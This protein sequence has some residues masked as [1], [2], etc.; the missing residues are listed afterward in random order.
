MLA[1]HLEKLSV[2]NFLVFVR[3]GIIASG[4]GRCMWPLRQRK[5]NDA[6]G[7]GCA[8]GVMVVRERSGQG[9]NVSFGKVMGVK[10]LCLV[11]CG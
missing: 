3:N 11:Y 9:V 5:E 10:C 4:V 2:S 1:G 7:V 8:E 6:V